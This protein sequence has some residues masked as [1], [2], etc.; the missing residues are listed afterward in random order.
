MTERAVMDRLSTPKTFG[1]QKTP[2]RDSGQ[3][4]ENTKP[5]STSFGVQQTSVFRTGVIG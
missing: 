3:I 5:A 1:V 2:A 4:L